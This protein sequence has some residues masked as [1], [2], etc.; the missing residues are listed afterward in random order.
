MVKMSVFYFVHFKIVYIILCVCFM[1]EKQ[2]VEN[3]TNKSP[4]VRFRD[5]FRYLASI[6]FLLWRQ[7][8]LKLAKSSPMDFP[9]PS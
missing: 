9:S 8:K 5:F 1:R 4:H 7:R 3:Y 6:K 2:E